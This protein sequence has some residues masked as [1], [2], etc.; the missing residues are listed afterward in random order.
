MYQTKN[1]GLN[2]TEMPKDTNMAFSFH[3]DLGYN[4]EAIDNLALSHRNITNC[5]LEIPH[6]I[7][8]E[9]VDG[10]LTLK[11]GSKV[12]VPNGENNFEEFIAPN[13]ISQN[14]SSG[15]AGQR[16]LVLDSTTHS[17]NWYLTRECYSSINQPDNYG[18]WWDLTNN[19]INKVESANIQ[20]LPI[21]LFTSDGNKNIKIDQVFNG[22]GYIGSTIFTL[23]GIKGLIPNGRNID[24]TLK[25]NTFTTRNVI[26]RSFTTPG[27]SLI[28]LNENSIGNL[29][30]FDYKYNLKE[31]RNY[32]GNAHY[33]SCFISN[34][35]LEN[36]AI[37]DFQP[38]KTFHAVDYNDY[39][40]KIAE[41]E[42][43]IET[44]QAAVKALQG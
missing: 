20:S 32:S 5:L 2:I 8:L 3:T 27:T 34:F 29:K 40:T 14:I 12:Y 43:K 35:T 9:L 10:V 23:P 21:M 26:T 15:V 39:S 4:F 37:T 28:F 44:L 11:E 1:M 22:F 18:L 33:N 30:N 19:V 7:K 16:L 41:L 13:D 42:S 36:N 38:R 25:N 31:N 24:E 6:D 17:F